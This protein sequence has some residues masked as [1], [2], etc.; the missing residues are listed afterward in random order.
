MDVQTYLRFQ[1]LEQHICKS[2]RGAVSHAVHKQVF[3]PFKIPL[4]KFG[5]FSIGNKF[6]KEYY[7]VAKLLEQRKVAQVGWLVTHWIAC[8]LA[9]QSCSQ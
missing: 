9:Q 4:L 2:S 8:L 6:R 3:D 1:S 5:A 7:L